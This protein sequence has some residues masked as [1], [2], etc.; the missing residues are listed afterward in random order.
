A[1]FTLVT[2]FLQSVS[3]QATPQ[4]RGQIS[5]DRDYDDGSGLS[6]INV[7]YVP[8]PTD[9]D[10]F[11]L[12][13]SFER[14]LGGERPEQW[15]WMITISPRSRMSL[16]FRYDIWGTD[17]WPSDGGP[18]RPGGTPGTGGTGGQLTILSDKP[19]QG[20][21][22]GHVDLGGGDPGDRAANAPGGDPGNPVHAGWS[23]THV[24]TATHTARPGA[25][26]TAPAGQ[27]GLSGSLT[28]NAA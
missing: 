28:V 4:P 18:A 20:S 15:Q 6:Y 10:D 12:T 14:D 17:R 16:E 9:L 27:K 8:A 22:A 21:L 1:S 3:Y 11:R 25:D 23:N 24:E 19:I 13:F 2:Q 26:W 7:T 5:I